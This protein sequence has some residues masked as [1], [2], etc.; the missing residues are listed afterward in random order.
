MAKIIIPE[1]LRDY[2]NNQA[3][4]ISGGSTLGAS[5][6]ELIAQYPDI[7][8][9][10]IDSNGKLINK[11]NIFIVDNGTG[12]I[13]EQTGINDSTEIKFIDNTRFFAN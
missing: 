12:M 2:T 1:S 4:Y 7:K 8:Q 5:I 6:T 9:H 13:N 11:F 10:L 3:V